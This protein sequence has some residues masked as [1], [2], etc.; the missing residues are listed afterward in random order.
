MRTVVALAVLVVTPAICVADEAPAWLD[1]LARSTAARDVDTGAD[2]VVLLDDLTVTVGE[3]GRLV[4]RRQYAVKVLTRAGAAAAVARE[5]YTTD[6]G[7]VR[8]MRAWVVA[9]GTATRL[10]NA[11]VADIALV[12]DDVYNQ[13]RMRLISASSRVEPGMVFG[14]ETEVAER[15]VFTQF[16][17]LLQNQLPV[18]S[19]RRTLTLPAGWEARSVTFNTAPIEPQRTGSSF[20]WSASNLSAPPDEPAGPSWTALVPRVAVTYFSRGRENGF[21]DWP[22]VSRWLAM[23]AEPSGAV[24]PALSTKARDLTAGATDDLDRVRRI[25]AYVQKVQ[26]ISIQL[27]TGRGGGYVPH[28]AT[29]VLAKNYGDCKDKANLMRA[30]LASVGIRSYL[31]AVYS[32]DPE[33]VRS[34]W[35]SP[36]QFNHMILAIAI[37]APVPAALR[38]DRLGALLIFD[39]TDEQTPVGELA[40]ADEGSLALIVAPDGGPL[41]RVPADTPEAS[42]RV[43][44]V[45]ASIDVSGALTANVVHTTRGAA[46]ALERGIYESLS[47]EEYVRM[48]EAAARRQVAGASL[49]IGQIADDRGANRFDLSVKLQAPGYAQVVQNRLLLVRPPRTLRAEL[50]A[51]SSATRRTSILLDAR[52]EQD[53]FDLALP[54]GVVVDEMPEP[55]KVETRFGRFSVAWQA[56][57]GH[58][59]RTLS[60]RMPRAVLPASAYAEL[61][62]FLEAFREA[63]NLPVVLMRR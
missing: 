62:A 58:V 54:S 27:G 15:T 16:D 47:R 26:Y 10:G 32:G 55:R 61:R 57:N 41:V 46:A 7:E 21:D 60:L 6:A 3:N 20:V 33:Y 63:E 9:G 40:A 38:H 37:D 48:L 35:P 42:P 5:I 8:A 34:E 36:Q 43:R 52:D 14:A 22:S 30:L 39:P 19:V 11:D 13:A 25:G 24:T 45:D 12:D 44:R 50:P 23:L 53:A 4:M 18:R 49:V 17:W 29:D 1:Q 31:V 59:T 28:P 56:Q 2:A 51:F